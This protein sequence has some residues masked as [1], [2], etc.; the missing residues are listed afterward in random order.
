MKNILYIAVFL[1]PSMLLAQDFFD[2]R[3]FFQAS[4]NLNIPRKEKA[5]YTYGVHFIDIWVEMLLME[6]NISLKKK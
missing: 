6:K 3:W 2:K 4:A 5:T 1:L